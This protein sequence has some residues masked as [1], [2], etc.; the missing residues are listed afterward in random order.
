MRKKRLYAEVV[1]Q[2]KSILICRGRKYGVKADLRK[3]NN[4]HCKQARDKVNRKKHNDD[5]GDDNMKSACGGL[6]V[7]KTEKNF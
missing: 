7:Q 3:C 6:S 1:I 4:D 2:L 5:D